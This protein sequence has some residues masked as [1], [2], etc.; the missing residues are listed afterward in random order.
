MRFEEVYG[1][2][3]QDRLTQRYSLNC[4]YWDAIYRLG[5]EREGVQ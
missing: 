3:N 1:R 5:I 2:W 4:C